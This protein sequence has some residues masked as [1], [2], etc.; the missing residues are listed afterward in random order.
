[1]KNDIKTQMIKKFENV[2][3][4][5]HTCGRGSI[6]ENTEI[7]RNLLVEVIKKYDIRTIADIG[8]GDLSWIYHTKWPH[9][10]EYSPYDLVPRHKDII[11]FD[12][13]SEIPPSVD[14]ILCRYVL[15]HFDH[16][17]LYLAAIDNIKKS[18]SKYL[19]M[20]L[21]KAKENHFSEKWGSEIIMPLVEEGFKGKRHHMF[22]GLWRLTEEL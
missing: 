22:Y 11:R 18:K 14:L 15:N 13:T 2:K 19:L 8:A 3:W 17:E 20:T 9:K 1:M 10:I 5:G 7:I 12:I 6:F 21:T 16:D 4:R